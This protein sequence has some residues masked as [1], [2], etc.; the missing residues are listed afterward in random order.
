MKCPKC[1]YENPSGVRYCVK[2]GSQMIPPI[3]PAN[4]KNARHRPKR[5]TNTHRVLIAA[6]SIFMV[7]G[8]GILALLLFLPSGSG[9]QSVQT[10]V[11]PDFPEENT[12]VIEEADLQEDTAESPANNLPGRDSNDFSQY[13]NLNTRT[14]KIPESELTL[15][16][17][18]YTDY[19]FD[20]DQ[21]N[22]QMIFEIHTA[23]NMIVTITSS[24]LNALPFTKSEAETA[25]SPT[26]YHTIQGEETEYYY[27]LQPNSSIV[28]GTII[29]CDNNRSTS[30][31]VVSQSLNS[32][33][34]SDFSQENKNDTKADKK[35]QTSEVY[36]GGDGNSEISQNEAHQYAT[37][38]E[39]TA[40][41]TDEAGVII[42]SSPKSESSSTEDSN[43][44]ASSRLETSKRPLANAA[45]M[46]V[47]EDLLASSGIHN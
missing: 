47:L 38:S 33:L 2:C 20:F 41:G 3:P 27:I 35:N 36:A 9:S 18:E 44:E 11:V 29:D 28:T 39:S 24:R 21:N 6:L 31:N 4:G 22:G 10:A 15:T 45:S 42:E 14:V 13:V 16:F 19:L 43:E 8:V 34:E 1:E 40:L 26:I 37:D 5:Q 17:P 30:V 32:T 12:D 23:D 46:K 7:I 25:D